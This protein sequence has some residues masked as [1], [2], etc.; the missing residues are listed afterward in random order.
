VWA[1]NNVNVFQRLLVT[2]IPGISVAYVS[3]FVYIYVCV[4][5]FMLSKVFILLLIICVQVC[6]YLHMNEDIGRG[7]KPK[8]TWVWNYRLSLTPHVG[9]RIQTWVLCHS[10]VSS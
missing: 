9:T 2:S 10:N 8:S 4:F 1:I 3:A 7:Q 6:R 5:L